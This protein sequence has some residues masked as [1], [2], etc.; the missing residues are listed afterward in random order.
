M[1]CISSWRVS[2][3][4]WQSRL[5]LS[6][7][8]TP[9]FNRDSPDDS[10]AE[11]NICAFPTFPQDSA[12]REGRWGRDCGACVSRYALSGADLAADTGR[13]NAGGA[14]ADRG[15]HREHSTL[16]EPWPWVRSGC[17]ER[18]G[19]IIRPHQR[20]GKRDAPIQRRISGQ[21]RQPG[22]GA[23]LPSQFG[24]AS[25]VDALNPAHRQIIEATLICLEAIGRT[26]PHSVVAMEYEAK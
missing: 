20:L 16:T 7:V 9:P 1:L 10:R 25:E 6:N 2:G 8:S 12:T 17:H 14:Q 15:Q 3:A 5:R 11:V 21:L 24:S 19:R 26:K 23:L 4:T 18:S 22:A 13:G